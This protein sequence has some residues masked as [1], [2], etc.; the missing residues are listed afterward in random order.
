MA[1]NK[2]TLQASAQQTAS[3][4]GAWQAI[5]TGSMVQVTV[6]VTAGSSITRFDAFVQSTDAPDTDSTGT[7]VPCDMVMMSDPATAATPTVAANQRNIVNNKST[8]TAQRFVGVIKHFPGGNI[9][10]RWI[11][12]GTNV[13]FSVVAETK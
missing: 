7:D 11:L 9:R 12:N 5:K 4:N 13:T 1:Y 3:G 10:A 8:T 2:L 6:D